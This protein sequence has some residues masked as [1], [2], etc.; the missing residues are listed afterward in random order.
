MSSNISIL[1]KKFIVYNSLTELVMNFNFLFFSKS[2]FVLE[3]VFEKNYN[4]EN[5]DD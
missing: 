5:F 2:N 3:L 1:T 4:Y